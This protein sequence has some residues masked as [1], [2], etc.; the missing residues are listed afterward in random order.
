MIVEAPRSVVSDEIIRVFE[1]HLGLVEIALRNDYP[2]AF[3]EL[4]AAFEH[5]A[6]RSEPE[7]LAQAAA[8]CRRVL[9]DL[10]DQ[11]YPASNETRNG[12]KLDQSRYV[13]RLWAYAEERMESDTNAALVG[14]GLTHLGERIDAV[15]K[16]ACKGDHADLTVD[17]AY[18]CAVQ[19]LLL[20]SDLL[21]L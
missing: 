18:R 10:A 14:A 13:N 2:D 20:V 12:H 8:S 4:C 9:S 5:L 11:L 17:E 16:L 3:G 19:T 21:V 15:H 7:E 1:Q 6:D